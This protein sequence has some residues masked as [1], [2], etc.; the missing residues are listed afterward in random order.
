VLAVLPIPVPYPYLE[1][2]DWVKFDAHTGYGCGPG[3][4]LNGEFRRNRNFGKTA[5]QPV[6][7]FATTSVAEP[8]DANPEF[9]GWKT[10]FLLAFLYKEPLAIQVLLLWAFCLAVFKRRQGEESLLRNDLFLWALPLVFFVKFSFFFR[11]QIGYRYVLPALPM[12]YIFCARVVARDDRAPRW[13]TIVAWALLGHLAVVTF[14][15]YPHYLSYFNELMWDRKMA[16]TIHADSNLDWG[17]DLT[18]VEEFLERHPQ[19]QPYPAPPWATEQAARSGSP[20]GLRHA[21]VGR[22]AKPGLVIVGAT[23]LVGIYPHDHEYYRWL[24][25]HFDPVGHVCYSHL[26]YDLTEKELRQVA[27]AT[28]SG[29][30]F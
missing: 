16:Y 10:Y 24:R 15:N 13:R 14:A 26:I 3:L 2:L 22:P 11:L 19:A 6:N 18:C 5:P 7:L 27:G 17:Q 9:R 20:V 1:G 21:G 12:L 28:G 23:D 30:P 25:E 8:A 4:Y 29:K